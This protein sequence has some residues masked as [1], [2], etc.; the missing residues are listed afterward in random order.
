MLTHPDKHGP[1]KHG[2]FVQ[3]TNAH[4]F[5]ETLDE[6]GLARY[7]KM[8]EERGK[9]ATSP[10]DST[11]TASDR[12]PRGPFAPRD[13]FFAGDFLGKNWDFRGI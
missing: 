4:D 12:R 10:S 8:L 2:E 13:E 11:S 9:A 1:E 5:L 7:C 3:L 6:K